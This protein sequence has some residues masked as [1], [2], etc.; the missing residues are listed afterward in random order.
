V[1]KN[2]KLT[3]NGFTF[4]PPQFDT[5]TNPV[6]T[7]I[8][9]C[10]HLGS[11]LNISR[12]HRAFKP[13]KLGQL[14]MSLVEVLLV[15]GSILG[16]SVLAFQANKSSALAGNV[17]VEQQRAKAL[18]DTIDSAYGSVGSIGTLS[19]YG[20]ISAGLAPAPMISGTSLVHSFGGTVVVAPSATGY[21]ITYN[22]MPQDACNSF[23]TATAGLAADVT[24]NNTDV[25]VSGVLDPATLVAQC[26]SSGNAV[27]LNFIAATSQQSAGAL[28]SPSSTPFAPKIGCA[29][30]G[31]PVQ[32]APPGVNPPAVTPPAGP[33]GPAARGVVAAGN[34]GPAC[35]TT[36]T[37]TQTVVCPV[38]Q[39]G[40]HIQIQTRS[41]GGSWGPWVDYYNGCQPV[42]VNGLVAPPAASGC[43]L[44]A[45][46][47]YIQ[48][49]NYNPSYPQTWSCGNSPAAWE[50]GC[51][52]VCVVPPA[53]TA[54]AGDTYS[55]L[56]GQLIS[57]SGPYLYNSSGPRARTGTTTYYCPLYTGASAANPTTYSAYSPAAY[58]CVNACVAPATT[59]TSVAAPALT[60]PA[61][62]WISDAGAYYHQTSAP[63]TQTQTTTWTCPT[64]IAAPTSSTTLSSPSPSYTCVPKT[65]PDGSAFA[66]YSQC[67]MLDFERGGLNGKNC[68]QT[69]VKVQAGNLLHKNPVDIYNNFRYTDLPGPFQTAI[70]NVL[71]IIGS[72]P[73]TT[74]TTAPAGSGSQQEA[75]KGSAGEYGYSVGGT[76]DM[77]SGPISPWTFYT[78]YSPAPPACDEAHYGEV[79]AEYETNSTSTY[80][81]NNSV[82]VSLCGCVGTPPVVP[83]GEITGTTATGSNC[84]KYPATLSASFGGGDLASDWTWKWT[85]RYGTGI[86]CSSNTTNTCTVSADDDYYLTG[87]YK[88]GAKTTVG[89]VCTGSSFD[90]SGSCLTCRSPYIGGGSQCYNPSTGVYQYCP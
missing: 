1:L 68:G 13:S 87:T 77:A 88:G 19:T 75:F 29:G 78:G 21:T 86:A 45:D 23:T 56:S 55:C 20:L 84:S 28:G 81:P 5:L 16:V 10:L 38:G 34:A 85:T 6:F 27:V 49:Q 32:V 25:F 79:F 64:P 12:N 82:N 66:W 90:A 76:V 72:S 11:V 37:Q 7:G 58:N 36:T 65:C 18:I 9:L 57:D 83:A 4:L 73:A 33:G 43:P 63:Q 30:V 61:N 67:T 39:T 35:A 52:A 44:C 26:V 31:C 60:C 70:T 69:N 53:T 24:V 22:N 62:Y 89:F 54:P 42:P 40:N 50:S 17:Q 47:H 15:V 48:N 80:E 74:F 2:K 46:G 51:P 14:G 71:S 41:C 8:L 3:V 59:S